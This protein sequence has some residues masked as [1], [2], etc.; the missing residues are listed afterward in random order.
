MTA[1][2]SEVEQ[3]RII[4]LTDEELETKTMGSYNL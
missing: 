1:Q 4:R 2:T 3:P